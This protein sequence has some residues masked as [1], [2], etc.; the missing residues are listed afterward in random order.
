MGIPT[1]PRLNTFAI[2]LG[3]AVC[4]PAQAA[5]CNRFAVE[6]ATVPV[7]YQYPRGLEQADRLM[8]NVPHEA[9]L[10]LVGDSLLANWP[11]DMA[12]R[13]FGSDRIW[14]FAVGGS[15]T[16]NTLW[17]LGQLP[18]DGPKP[19]EVLMLVGTNNLTRDDMPACAIAA[20]IEAVAAAAH[21]RW[22]GAKIHLMGIPPRGADFRFRNDARLA[23]NENVRA[24]A[25]KR[26]YLDY[27]EVDA[28]EITCGQYDRPLQV[29]ATG[30]D[31]A[32]PCPNYA[33]DF[34]HF[35]RPGYDVIFLALP[36]AR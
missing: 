1:L 25:A 20:G 36:K 18:P 11:D 10:I 6:V 21:D 5:E 2:L 12:R 19:A 16:Q 34:G 23:V 17:Q 35:K 33:D 24:W 3:L 22:P 9:D 13:Q 26:A 14:N 28:S 15:V 27:F 30:A 29:A 8:A 32:S 7:P 4:G 31:G